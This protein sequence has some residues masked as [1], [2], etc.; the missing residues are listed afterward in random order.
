MEGCT[1]A[2]GFDAETPG[3]S[4]WA[5]GPVGKS[6]SVAAAAAGMIFF[7]GGAESTI[8]CHLII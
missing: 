7:A 1:E 8:K 6:G 5:L 2:T 3:G 4:G